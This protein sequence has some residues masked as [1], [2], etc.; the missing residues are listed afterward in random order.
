MVASVRTTCARC[1]TVELPVEAG[2]LMIPTRVGETRAR[3][4]FCCPSCAEV[5]EQELTERSTLLLMDAGI[6][7]GEPIEQFARSRP[8]DGR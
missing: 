1:G 4:E 6:S 2:R 8:D 3:L 7:V 5:Q